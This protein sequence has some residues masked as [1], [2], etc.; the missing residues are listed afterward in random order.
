MKEREL[1]YK[2]TVDQ[3]VKDKDDLSQQMKLMQEGNEL[4]LLWNLYI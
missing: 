4:V 3:L 1:D 2:K